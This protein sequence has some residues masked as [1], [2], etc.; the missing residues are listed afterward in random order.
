MI[1]S[2]FIPLQ[3][4]KSSHS[5]TYIFFLNFWSFTSFNDK[6]IH[7]II[8]KNV[9]GLNQT[10]ILDFAMKIQSCSIFS[11]NMCMKDNSACCSVCKNSMQQSSDT[12]ICLY[13]RNFVVPAI[14]IILILSKII[15]KRKE[16]SM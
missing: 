11:I 6:V 16:M 12:K 15:V 4:T 7:G 10:Q 2:L 14:E 8:S 3:L 1:F 9:V 5:I 13:F